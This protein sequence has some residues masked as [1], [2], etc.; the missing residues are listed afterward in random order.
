MLLLWSWEE[1]RYIQSKVRDKENDSS[2]K[3]GQDIERKDNF[4]NNIEKSE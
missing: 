4:T 1:E 2:E 3:G